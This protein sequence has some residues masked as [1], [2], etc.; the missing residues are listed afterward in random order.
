METRENILQELKDISPVVAGLGTANLFSV[1]AG[2]FDQ[3]PAIILSRVNAEPADFGRSHP[4]K[5]PAGYFDQLADN[6]LQTIKRTEQ[7]VEE[8]LNELAPILNTISKKPVYTVPGGYFESLELAIPLKLSKPAAKVIGFGK[9]KRV[10]QYAVAACTAGIL[11]AGAFL[12]TRSNTQEQPI[13]YKDAVNM[14]VSGELDKLNETEISSYIESTPNI[15]YVM[16]VSA[17]EI[18]IEEYLNAASDEEIDAYLNESADTG[19]DTGSGI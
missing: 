9:T 12:F 3:L 11:I 16:N 6:I 8:E 19:S 5:I 2:Y 1:P 18:N 10:M 4:F 15:G 7:S 17:D 14:N 13:S